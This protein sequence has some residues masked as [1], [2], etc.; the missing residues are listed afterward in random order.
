[1]VILGL[2][3]LQQPETAIRDVVKRLRGNDEYE[4][5]LNAEKFDIMKKEVE[6][7]EDKL[8]N[9][10]FSKLDD[11]IKVID[12]RCNVNVTRGDLRTVKNNDDAMM[13]LNLLDQED[14][15]EEEF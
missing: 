7:N 10:S 1:M 6:Q 14:D 13:I 9:I 4:Y 5:K 2:K 8:L 15:F 3:I 12:K 11:N